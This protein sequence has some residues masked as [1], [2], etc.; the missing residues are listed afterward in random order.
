MRHLNRNPIGNLRDVNPAKIVS[1]VTAWFLTQPDE[2]KD[3]IVGDL[4]AKEESAA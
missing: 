2:V 1:R 4:F 3:Q